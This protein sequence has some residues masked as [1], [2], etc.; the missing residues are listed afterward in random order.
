MKKRCFNKN[1]KSYKH[2]GGRGITICRRWL[3]SFDNFLADMGTKPSPNHSLDRIDNNGNYAPWNCRW[4]THSQ[5][6]RNRRPR[7]EWGK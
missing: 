1:F 4:A 3:Q 2:Y 6:A 7:S 5:Q